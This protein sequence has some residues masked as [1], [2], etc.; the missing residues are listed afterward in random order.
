M[1]FRL[2]DALDDVARIAIRGSL[3]D[4][5][6]FDKLQAACRTI[7]E[8]GHTACILDFS[9]GRVGGLRGLLVLAE[10]TDLHPRL[11]LVACGLSPR[12]SRQLDDWG[13]G[14]HI[15]VL[16]SP[17]EARQDPVISRSI[18]RRTP[19]LVLSPPPMA[20]GPGG[21]HPLD[22]Q[23]LGPTL[24]DA[25]LDDLRRQGSTEIAL[26][27]ARP[28]KGPVEV[29]P[30]KTPGLPWHALDP[31]APVVLRYLSCAARLPIADA[32][33][34]FRGS[35]GKPVL[36]MARGA[37]DGC[38]DGPLLG[39]AILPAGIARQ[40]VTTGEDPPGIAELPTRLAELGARPLLVPTDI[41]PASLATPREA[42]S[43]LLRALAEARD[44]AGFPLTELD[45]PSPG[46]WL[47]AGA[48][49]GKRAR[50]TGPVLLGRGAQVGAGAT[51]HG[52][53]I[54]GAGA[55]V[56]R[57]ALV[58]DSL[59][60]DGHHVG[61]GDLLDGQV[62]GR[63]GQFAIRLPYGQATDLPETGSRQR[64]AI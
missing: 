21:S 20:Q 30:L 47:A 53:V 43:T 11:G 3:S 45:Q 22:W 6:A 36:F 64:R 59:V 38:R 57:R 37:R 54:L 61:P 28:A 4:A 27:P 55:S 41:P 62:A 35:Q 31:Q 48:R 12:A 25:M 17:A 32:V 10:I 14:R 52:P 40:A 29:V 51:L 50:V 33:A 2:D 60:L 39:T 15:R 34:R 42:A 63:S 1:R 13:L 7:E 58:R 44:L 24:R 23:V 56:S 5:D 16:G 19:V 18:A 46:I 26:L 49:L 9:R 8:N